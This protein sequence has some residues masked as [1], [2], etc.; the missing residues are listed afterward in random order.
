MTEKL[1]ERDAYTVSF[2]AV[3]RACRRSD[4]GYEIAIDRTAF[5]PEGGGQP[6]DTGI[7]AGVAVKDVQEK[8]GEIW[9][10]AEQPLEIGSRISGRIDWESRFRRMQ[11]HTGEHLI[12]GLMAQQF[13]YHNV[14]FHMGCREML[15]DF[16]GTLTSDQLLEIEE[17]ANRA[18]CSNVEVTAFYPEKAML[19]KLSYR[20]KRNDLKHVRIVEIAGYDRCACCAP[21]VRRTGEIGLIKIMDHMR[22]KGGTR[23][24]LLCG[25]DAIDA[26]RRRLQETERISHLLSSPQDNLYSAAERLLENLNEAR[27]ENARWKESLAE[28]RLA[29][30]YAENG[31]LCL[32]EEIND[33]GYLQKLAEIGSKKCHGVCAV[34]S[35]DDFTGYRF[36]IGSNGFPLK[37]AAGEILSALNGR[38]GGSDNLLQGSV[39]CTRAEIETYFSGEFF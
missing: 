28:A 4:N 26:V 38:G 6:S 9:H 17:K 16:D 5:F 23:L 30:L 12:S 22:Y 13:G 36:V 20:S 8:S 34:F 37:Q 33:T 24:F 31:T 18:V 11:K 39:R 2:D 14:G 21:H 25:F 15:V 29:A 27:R 35:G 3:V 10:T 7:L 1:Y 19:E 32:F